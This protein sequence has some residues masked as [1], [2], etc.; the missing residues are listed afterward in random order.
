MAAEKG[1]K[2]ETL[3]KEFQESKKAFVEWTREGAESPEE[4]TNR[5]S[6]FFDVSQS[7]NYVIFSQQVMVKN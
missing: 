3:L 1:E 6:S 5:F 4:C 2:I 7:S